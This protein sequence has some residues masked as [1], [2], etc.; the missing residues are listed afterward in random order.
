MKILSHSVDEELVAKVVSLGLFLI[1]YRSSDVVDYPVLIFSKHQ[2]W[3]LTSVKYVIDVFEE[4]FVKDLGVGHRECDRRAS[5]AR[6]E[7]HFFYEVTEVS[8]TVAF[9]DFDLFEVHT[10]DV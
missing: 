4:S 10:V 5:D 1:G 8:H 6:F 7:H 3:N 2:V 9:N